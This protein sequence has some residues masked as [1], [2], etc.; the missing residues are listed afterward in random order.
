[1][2]RELVI[3]GGG[4]HTRVLIGMAQAA[5][6]NIK[7]IITSNAALLGEEVLDVPVL[8]L[9]GEVALDPAQIVLINGVGNLASR[10]GSGLAVR[11]AIYQ[12]YRAR[13][14]DFLPL[15]SNHA[16]VQPHV[17]MGEGV[18]VMPGAVIQSGAII[19]ENVIVNTR[20]SIDHDAVIYPHCHIAPAAVLCGHVVVGEETH[21][22]AGAVIIQGIRIGCNVVVGAGAV[23]THH[24]PDNVIIRPPASEQT[25]QKPAHAE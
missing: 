20:A 25:R 11:A 6:L 19:G 8:G 16:V 9:E 13:G 17:M 23:V 5:G 7:G 12:R 10:A 1:M 3:I 18:Q 15:M 22:G 14:F 24:V 21:I 2:K 4:G